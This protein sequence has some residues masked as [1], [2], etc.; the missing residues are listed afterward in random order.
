[1][2]HNSLDDFMD[3]LCD[4]LEPN[5]KMHSPCVRA[6]NYILFSIFYIGAVIYFMGFR[7]D[8]VKVL[9]NEVF[10]FEAALMTG[11]FLSAITA[12]A[13]LCV[14]DMC[15][16]KWLLAVPFTLFGVFLTK[17]AAEIAIVGIDLSH[18]NWS[19]YHCTMDAGFIV[20]I[21]T[22]AIVFMSAKGATTRPA[23]SAVMSMLAM[24]A[25]GLG[26][27]RFTCMSDALTH[28]ALYHILPFV[29]GGGIIGMIISRLYRW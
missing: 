4:D 18:I 3:K 25:L 14:P 19:H 27:L 21:P 17:V 5:C 9:Q 7:P 8:L 24:G 26:T 11:L 10:V 20:A 6:L 12:N 23:L 22:A 28:I 13:W 2:S 1:M 15:D 29:L 16:K